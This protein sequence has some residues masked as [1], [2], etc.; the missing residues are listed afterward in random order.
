MILTLALLAASADPASLV[1][2]ERAFARASIENGTMVAFLEYLTEGAVVFRPRPVD[3]RKFYAER[4][5]SDAALS[6]GPA[7]AEIAHSGDFGYTGGPWELRAKPGEE[8]KTFGH[9]VSVWKKQ[10]DGKW[11]VV[12]DAGIPHPQRIA[13]PAKVAFPA[14]SGQTRANAISAE[15]LAFDSDYSVEHL[16]SD[17]RVYRAGAP[18]SQGK[19]TLKDEPRVVSKFAGADVA[20]SGDLGYTYGIAEAPGGQQFSYLRIWRRMGGRW[21]I[22]LDLALEIRE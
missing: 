1:D 22:A 15:L 5:P 9:Y 6:W 11:R 12:A 10:K 17:A 14:H 8:P 2:A 21:R 20:A 19:A 4:G 18:P 7:F 3:G 16:A 13:V